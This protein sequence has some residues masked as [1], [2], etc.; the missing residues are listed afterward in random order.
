MSI[1]RETIGKSIFS[2]HAKIEKK[3]FRKR[4]FNTKRKDL[5]HCK[6]IHYMKTEKF[7]SKFNSQKNG[8][9]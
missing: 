2:T 9:V 7:H 5:Y 6:S 8:G 4:F 1:F 3:L